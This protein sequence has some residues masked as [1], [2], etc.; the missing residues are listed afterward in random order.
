MAGGRRLDAAFDVQIVD[1]VVTLVIE[2]RSGALGGDRARNPDYNEALALLL[3]RL[4]QRGA[5]LVD[6]VVDS[7][8]A[9]RAHPDPAAR[10]LALDYPVDLA[11]A[12]PAALRL[13]LRRA[14]A[15]AA[16][17]PGASSTGSGEKRLRLFLDVPG[18]APRE[19]RAALSRDAPALSPGAVAPRSSAGSRAGQAQ[20]RGQGRAD[21]AFRRAVELHAMSLAVE[22]FQ[23]EG[24]RVED[25][26]ADHP[27]DLRCTR[28][29]QE[30]HVEVKGTTG[31]GE[32]VNLT[33]GE[34]GHHRQNPLRAVLFVAHTIDVAWDVN[35]PRA[36]DGR[37]YVIEPWD[38]DAGLLEPTAFVWRP[39]DTPAN[40]LRHTLLV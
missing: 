24:W 15:A 1:D 39:G 10:R 27:Y 13:E 17:R 11:A 28:E 34:V 18:D 32:Q 19:L 29:R 40:C 23:A 31:L 35:G 36:S 25:T 38:V 8:A 16:R 37:V 2:S 7:T 22:H 4:G 21:A 26:S 9:R 6:A 30:R 33:A 3:A 20:R 5:S 12:D 14:A